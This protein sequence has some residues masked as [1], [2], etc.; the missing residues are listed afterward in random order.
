MYIDAS[1]KDMN[2]KVVANLSE[3]WKKFQY[4][5]GYWRNKKLDLHNLT[6][7]TEVKAFPKKSNPEW[8]PQ[9]FPEDLT[10]TG[11]HE[12]VQYDIQH[13]TFVLSLDFKMLF[14]NCERHFDFSKK[15]NIYIKKHF[16]IPAG[17]ARGF[18]LTMIVVF[19]PAPN[20]K[21]K[22]IRE[23]DTTFASAGLPSLGKKRH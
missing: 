14:E 19:T 6:M 17:P 12:N 18:N 16:E 9:S 3:G 23:W 7:R 15:R 4:S 20:R 1:L 22:D 13:G 2:F 10:I 21:P 11:E 8:F 5:F